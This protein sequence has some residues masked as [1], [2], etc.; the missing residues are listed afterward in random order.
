MLC[1]PAIEHFTQRVFGLPSALFFPRHAD[2]LGTLRGLLSP[3][4][5]PAHMHSL[6]GLMAARLHHLCP[7]DADVSGPS[8]FC[9]YSNLCM[10]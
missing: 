8:A 5:L 4:N 6:L 3:G 7:E 9:S 1:R 10:V 2:L